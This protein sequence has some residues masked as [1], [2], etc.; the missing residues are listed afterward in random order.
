MTHEGI[1]RSAKAV[2]WQ[3]LKTLEGIR[4]AKLLG[5]VFP[6]KKI[7]AK[8]RGNGRFLLGLGSTFSPIS[9]AIK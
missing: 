1:L 2:P 7:S 6:R 8:M 9:T 5:H 3:D 4:A